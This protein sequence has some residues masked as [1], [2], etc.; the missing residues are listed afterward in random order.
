MLWGPWPS[1]VP[2][3]PPLNISSH[4]TQVLSWATE[5]TVGRDQSGTTVVVLEVLGSSPIPHTSL[6]FLNFQGVSPT[7]SRFPLLK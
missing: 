7:Y 4:T 3:L 5:L 6:E 2:Q 1:G